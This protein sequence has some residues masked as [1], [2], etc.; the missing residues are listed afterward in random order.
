MCD[1]VSIEFYGCNLCVFSA[2]FTKT[3]VH[4]AV[5]SWSDPGTALR[6]HMAG[7]GELTGAVQ[8]GDFYEIHLRKTVPITQKVTPTITLAFV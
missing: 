1:V 6:T 3:A 5:R 8:Q 2:L 7:E 4:Y